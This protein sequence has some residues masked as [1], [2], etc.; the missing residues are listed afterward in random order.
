MNPQLPGTMSVEKTTVALCANNESGE[1]M[2]QA[3][4]TDRVDNINSGKTN[5][6][7]KEVLLKVVCTEHFFFAKPTNEMR[8]I[9][10][11]N[12]SALYSKTLVLDKGAG[13]ISSTK[14]T[15][16]RTG[17]VELRVYMRPVSLRN[18]RVD[19][20]TKNHFVDREEVTLQVHTSFGIARSLAVYNVLGIPYISYCIEGIFPMH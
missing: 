3:T 7:A 5:T 19:Q 9:M 20:G 14:L 1:K 13:Q 11:V 8:I 12:K 17:K 4:T 16:G 18:E 6:L 10:G 15:Q 2:T